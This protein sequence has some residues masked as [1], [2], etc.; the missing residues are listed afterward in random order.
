MQSLVVYDVEGYGAIKLDIGLGLIEF[1]GTVG[2]SCFG[3]GIE[4]GLQGYC[5]LLGAR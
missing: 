5:S 2:S 4:S 3:V 1:K